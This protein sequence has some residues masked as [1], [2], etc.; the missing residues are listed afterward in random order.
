[1]QPTS[2]EDALDLV[3][4]RD[5]RRDQ[6]AGRGR[7]VRVDVRP[8]R[9]GRRLREHL[10]HRKALFRRH[11]GQERPHPQSPGLQFRGS[12]HPRHGRRRVEQLLRGRRAR[13][14]D[15]GDRHQSARDPDQLLPQSLGAQSPRNLARQEEEGICRRGGRAGPHHHHRS[16]AD[17]DGRRVRGRSRQGSCPASG[18]GVRDR[19]RAVQRLAHL[20]R[21]QGLDRQ[22]VH[23]RPARSWRRKVR[24]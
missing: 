5:R 18:A 16:A 13:R 4:Q 17:R 9:L 24:R 21:R 14:H 2:W 8:R 19:P 20:H 12:R 11:E 15:R 1:M 10:G 6:R 23:R 22:G 3:A 7:A